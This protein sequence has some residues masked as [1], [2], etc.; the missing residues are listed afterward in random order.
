M[1]GVSLNSDHE[2]FIQFTEIPIFRIDKHG[3]FLRTCIE[4]T[5]AGVE[6]EILVNRPSVDPHIALLARSLV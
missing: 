1:R 5:L 3:P 2:E 6:P 4:E